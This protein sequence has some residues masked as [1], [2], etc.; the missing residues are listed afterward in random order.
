MRDNRK[1][2]VE[3]LKGAK[4]NNVNGSASCGELSY[5]FYSFCALP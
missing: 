2:R 1:A 4:Q 5:Y 3:Q